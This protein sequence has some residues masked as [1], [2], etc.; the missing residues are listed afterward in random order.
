MNDSLSDSE[1]LSHAAPGSDLLGHVLVVD[2]TPANVR[3]LTGILKVEGYEIET[4]SD[5]VAALAAIAARVPDVVL[6]DAMMPGMDGFE[7]CRRIKSE[8]TTAFLPVVMVTALTETEDRVRALEAGADD[9]LAKPVDDIE[10][11][12]R[13][14]SL[15]RV[16]R[17]HQELEN[18]H[19][20]LK[21]LEAMRDSMT[22]M[23]VHDLRTPLTTL[24][25]PLEM[26]QS[27]Q[28]GTLEPL[29]DEIIAMST[30]SGHRLL[31]LVNQILDVAKMESGE[32]IPNWSEVSAELMVNEALEQLTLITHQHKITLSRDIEPMPLFQADEDLLRR[33]LA[34]LIG[35]AIKFTPEPGEVEISARPANKDENQKHALK[36][37]VLFGVRDNGEGIAEADRERIFDKFGQAGS[38]KSERKTSTGLGLTFCRLAVEAH[39]G[40]IWVESEEGEG[41]TFFFIVPTQPSAALNTKA[42]L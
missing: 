34:N 5:G 19:R 11:V 42:Q 36:S 10:V 7:V 12:A 18:A 28:F 35:N 32:L 37:G 6:L 14:E 39:G 13:V 16:R 24:L 15:V 8:P 2:D 3:L 21:K 30:R 1:T 23:L 4:A 31:G 25:G 41:S 27:G 20:E 17:Q 40:H 38:R 22:A 26:L 9:F 33:V 29:Q